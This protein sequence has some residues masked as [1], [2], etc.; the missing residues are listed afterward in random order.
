M[1]YQDYTFHFKE[2]TITMP[3]FTE[4]YAKILA[5]EEASK[6]GWDNTIIPKEGE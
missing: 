5:Q 4:S 3:A 1:K 2:G 6:R